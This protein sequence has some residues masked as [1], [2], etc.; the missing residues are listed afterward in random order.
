MDQDKVLPKEA[1][2]VSLSREEIEPLN[3]YL[4]SVCITLLS[5]NQDTFHKIIHSE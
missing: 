2:S 3:M 5:V 1:H 4:S